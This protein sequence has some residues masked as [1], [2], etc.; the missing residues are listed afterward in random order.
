[1]NRNLLIVTIILLVAIVLGLVYK[2]DHRTHTSI[3]AEKGLLGSKTTKIERS[4]EP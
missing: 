1:M 2:L 4:V 3:T